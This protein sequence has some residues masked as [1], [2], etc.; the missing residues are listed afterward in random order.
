MLKKFTVLCLLAGLLFH[1]L[2]SLRAQDATP[3]VYGVPFEGEFTSDSLQA[4][5]IFEGK[6]GEVIYIFPQGTE[7]FST[8]EFGIGLT[9]ARGAALGRLYNKERLKPVLIAELPASS[10]YTITLTGSTR[11]SY[12]LELQQTLNLLPNTQ[13]EGTI[14]ADDSRFYIIKSAQPLKIALTYTRLE[15]TFS[16]ELRI[17]DFEQGFPREVAAISGRALSTATLELSLEAGVEYLI[18]LAQKPFDFASILETVTPQRY[19][20]S[21]TSLD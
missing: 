9:D 6:A 5:F 14:S 13:V 20:I 7:L 10:R 16:P 2:L 11:G 8:L 12:R 3:I 4:R 19:Q 1:G 21:V 15:G 17:E 18:T